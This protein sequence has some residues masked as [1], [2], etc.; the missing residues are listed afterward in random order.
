MRP[1]AC[2]PSSNA[3]PRASAAVD[4]AAE[5]WKAFRA[6]GRAYDAEWHRE[7]ISPE[8]HLA[9]LADA[10]LATLAAPPVA[11]D[12]AEA[13]EAAERLAAIL[14]TTLV[15]DSIDEAAMKLVGIVRE[16]ARLRAAVPP[17]EI[18]HG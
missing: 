10:Y 6:S 7:L 11:A 13:S 3:G 14:A 8:R 17:K 4:A 1:K 9:V 12:I 5:L 2:A 15:D 18:E 16:L